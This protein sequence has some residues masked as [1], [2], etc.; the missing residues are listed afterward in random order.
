MEENIYTIYLSIALFAI[1]GV[2]IRIELNKIE[3]ELYI[4][5]PLILTNSI[6]C[7]LLGFINA[8]KSILCEW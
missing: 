2:L 1:L 6:G 3:G 8:F 7:I 4:Y 5:L